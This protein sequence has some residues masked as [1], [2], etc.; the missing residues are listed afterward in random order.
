MGGDAGEDHA[1]LTPIRGLDVFRQLLFHDDFNRDEFI[2]V[3]DCL[4]LSGH[5]HRLAAALTNEPTLRGPWCWPSA[6]PSVLEY[7]INRIPNLR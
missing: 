4:F 3:G 7:L 5:L 2:R 6:L 1:L